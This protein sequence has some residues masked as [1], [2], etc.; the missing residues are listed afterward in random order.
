MARIQGFRFPPFR[1]AGWQ[2][3]QYMYER[4]RSNQNFER[5]TPAGK[6]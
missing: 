1:Q 3:E 5:F 4:R 6:R 2:G